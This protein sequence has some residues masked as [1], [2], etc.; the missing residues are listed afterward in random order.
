[1]YFAAS[2]RLVTM[3]KQ[4]VNEAILNKSIKVTA[5]E[6]VAAESVDSSL[7]QIT[8]DG[9]TY[10]FVQKHAHVTGLTSGDIVHVMYG[11]N[12][13]MTIIGIVA[14]DISLASA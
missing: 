6:W 14:G 9:D 1:M 12:T 13:P 11:P 10:H 3:I 7:S 2:D 5:A 8:L 4:Y